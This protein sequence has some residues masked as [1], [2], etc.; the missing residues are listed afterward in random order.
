MKIQSPQ[1]AGILGRSR[2]KQSGPSKKHAFEGLLRYHEPGYSSE[3]EDAPFWPQGRISGRRQ[4]REG[5]RRS[6][7]RGV[8]C[9]QEV[10]ALACSLLYVCPWQRLRT[11]S[12]QNILGSPAYP[13]F[14]ARQAK[15]RLAHT[16]SKSSIKPHHHHHPCRPNLEQHQAGDLTFPP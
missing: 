16:W 1:C 12:N 2:G 5:H 11:S 6:P 15:S 7:P 3:R 9:Q 13:T 8:M 10:L 14:G 4:V